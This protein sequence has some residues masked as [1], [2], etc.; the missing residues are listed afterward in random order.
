[1]SSITLRPLRAGDDARAYLSQVVL[2]PTRLQRSQALSALNATHV[3]AAL[4][5]LETILIN[6]QL[7]QREPAREISVRV[8]ELQRRDLLKMRLHGLLSDSSFPLRNMVWLLCKI[9][10]KVPEN[11]VLRLY[12]HSDRET[13]LPYLFNLFE[14]G[15]W[16]SVLH[17][18]FTPHPDPHVKLW[19][20]YFSRRSGLASAGDAKVSELLKLHRLNDSRVQEW[21][22]TSLNRGFYD[23][24]ILSVLI[25]TPQ[26]KHFDHLWRAIWK[27]PKHQ[28]LALKALDALLP[29]DDTST[30]ILFR[31]AH[32]ASSRA[33]RRFFA[34]K[35]A[36][37]ASKVVFHQVRS[38]CRSLDPEARLL[39]V[40]IVSVFGSPWHSARPTCTQLLLERLND[41]SLKVRRAAVTS[42]QLTERCRIQRKSTST[43]SPHDLTQ[44]NRAWDNLATLAP[45]HQTPREHALRVSQT[46]VK[47]KFLR[48][49]SV[50]ALTPAFQHNKQRD[51][52]KRSAVKALRRPLLSRLI[53]RTP[54]VALFMGLILSTLGFSIQIDTLE[55][56]ELRKSGGT[57]QTENNPPK[58]DKGTLSLNLPHSAILLDRS[59]TWYLY[60]RY[61]P[62]VSAAYVARGPTPDNTFEP[63]WN[64]YSTW[65]IP[66]M[67]NDI[68]GGKH[69]RAAKFLSELVT[70]NPQLA[71]QVVKRLFSRLPSSNRDD[72]AVALLQ[73]GRSVKPVELHPSAH[74]LSSECRSVIRAA[75]R[76]GW[77]TQNEVTLLARLK[78]LDDA[79]K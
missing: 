38:L 75:L 55:V 28:S 73:G 48:P 69:Q 5:T 22:E 17:N 3:E 49:R 35:L 78:E 24:D 76:S 40:E 61:K 37:R 66:I 33:K 23:K 42:L 45:S 29:F 59:N 30:E 72:L 57:R 77:K 10:L 70:L 46:E 34:D 43:L 16:T 26:P 13:V 62:E 39:G 79:R 53:K 63:N 2:L 7:N 14:R 47:T 65:L 58:A 15:K 31:R 19:T 9:Q 20:Q 44:L 21:V 50:A 18:I 32:A 54:Q 11:T 67:S 41:P 27:T 71:N 1:M 60:H 36:Q 56:A 74:Q 51:L 68:A 4:D 8:C 25:E 6:G 64:L 12:T 52:T